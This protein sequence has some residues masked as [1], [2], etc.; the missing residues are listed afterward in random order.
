LGKAPQHY[1]SHK[2]KQ[3]LQTHKQELIP[4]WLPTAPPEFMVLE[5]CWYISKNDLL[6][7]KCYSSFTAFRKKNKSILQN[8][9]FQSEYAKLSGRKCVSV[10]M[11]VG[12]LPSGVLYFFII[13]FGAVDSMSLNYSSNSLSISLRIHQIA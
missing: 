13:S 2:I 5:E 12:L 6:V 1:K 11:L 10:L 7:L 4:I 8:Y 9:A 3:Y